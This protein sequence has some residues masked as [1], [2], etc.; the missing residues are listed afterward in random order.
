MG[1]IDRHA[2]ERLVREH[3]AEVYRAALRVVRDEAL[4]LDATQQAFVE[5]LERRVPL[6]AARD[7]GKLLRCVAARQAAMLLRSERARAR[8]EELVAM[9][10]AEGV[11]GAD[12]GEREARRV[13]RE[14]VAGLPEELRLPLVLRYEEDLT[15]GE[16]GSALGLSET[17]VHGRLERA[18]Q[19]LRERLGRL[20]FAACLPRLPELLLAQESLAV[21]Q[22]VLP[23]LLALG[24]GTL[25]A[26]T[27]GVAVSGALVAVVAV[28]LV[29][30]WL[31]ERSDTSGAEPTSS[32]AP[33]AGGRTE[34][35]GRAPEPE[36][37]A[38]AAP[39]FAPGTPRGD[40]R[41]ELPSAR[42][43]GVV[44]DELGFAVADAEVG[45]ASLEFEGKFPVETSTTR[46]APDGSFVLD[47]RVWLESGQD[48]SLG[49]HTATLVQPAGT[50]R[51][52]SGRTA[53]FQ[54]IQLFA[55]VDERPGAWELALRVRDPSGRPV[56]GA[57]ARLYRSVRHAQGG[58]WTQWQA[59]GRADE[60]GELH[61][62]GE[63][64]GPRLIVVD[65]REQGFA[66][67]HERLVIADAG[68]LE[69]EARLQP[70]LALRGT[71][72][73][74][75]GRPLDAR[76]L[77]DPS[78]MPLYARGADAEDWFGAVFPEPGRFE[79]QALPDEPLELCFQSERWS[80]FTLADVRAGSAPLELRLKLRDDE[81]D[82][83]RH[84]AELHLRLIEAGSGA[85]LPAARAWTWLDR[86]DEE[87]PGLND[88]DFAP[89]ALERVV[90]QTCDSS[91][92]EEP[93]PEPAPE[94]LV[95]AGLAAGRYALR[96]R[97]EGYA[98][99][100]FG[101]VELAAREIVAGRRVELARGAS[102]SGRVLD[103]EQRPLAGA[104]VVLLGPGELSR[105]RLAEIDRDLRGTAG[106]GTLHLGGVESDASGAFRLE[107]VPTG[108]RLHLAVL[109]P[110]HD[111]VEGPPLALQEGSEAAPQE[112][113]AGAR[114]AR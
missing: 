10:R 58:S 89:L 7:A 1:R 4:A 76:R 106:R 108:L 41:A 96:V 31:D 91:R 59:G 83:G 75:L 12:A 21:P 38:L 100:L 25:S 22:H 111:P 63:D 3:H 61:L 67:L 71:L 28:L 114:R 81:R 78:G 92:G 102:V 113:R 18:Q 11:S 64:L 50:V 77:G 93:G 26:A 57:V 87:C 60:N 23:R 95:Q 2:F 74:E 53:A 19:E 90:V 98:P 5:L 88:G 29:P 51:V 42:I 66:P 49:V 85:P 54:R 104:R 9:Q 110:D 24:R 109:H 72:L 65:A 48:Y 86:I 73:D 46:T 17:G 33:L 39:A 47:V 97:L 13:L 56:A 62:R 36:R 32:A 80:P 94:A 112:L 70:G 30:H 68:T 82:I 52:H 27:L 20:G 37:L 107:H 105:R 44:R 14:L 99:A 45:A 101:P 35:E 34:L 8:R 40:S 79:I 16:I 6:G 55:P 15:L 43:V 69:H 103:D 84:D